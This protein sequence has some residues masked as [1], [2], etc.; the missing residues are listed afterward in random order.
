MD[1]VRV[2]SIGASRG[3]RAGHWR[4]CSPLIHILSETLSRTRYLQMICE[5]RERKKGVGWAGD[6]LLLPSFD[7]WEWNKSSPSH[8]FDVFFSWSEALAVWSPSNSHRRE[9]LLGRGEF[10]GN[11][12]PM[13][14]GEDSPLSYSNQFFLVRLLLSI[15]SQPLSRKLCWAS[16][17]VEGFPNRFLWSLSP[18]CPSPSQLSSF[19]LDLIPFLA[20]DLLSQG[21]LSSSLDDGKAPH[22]SHF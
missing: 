6:G 21:T 14:L 19:A 12:D 3:S 11:G 4:C 7:K 2:G 9:T 15:S 18:F 10:E 1:W 20:A 22:L 13:F 5:E 17:P 8:R 16:L